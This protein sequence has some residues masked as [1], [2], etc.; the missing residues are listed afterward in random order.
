MPK[1]LARATLVEVS[2]V[3]ITAEDERAAERI[4]KND[5]DWSFPDEVTEES[6][7]IEIVG[8]F[9]DGTD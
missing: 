9:P 8:K 4:A 6:W 5:I 2:E 1:Y 3:T 7:D